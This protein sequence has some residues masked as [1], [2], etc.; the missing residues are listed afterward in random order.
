[1]EN[2]QLRNA[3]RQSIYDDDNESEDESE[4]IKKAN[5]EQLKAMQNLT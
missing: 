1:M 3:L 5:Y 2:E 4:D